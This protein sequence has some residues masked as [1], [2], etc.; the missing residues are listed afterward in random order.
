MQTTSL[1]LTLAF[2]INLTFTTRAYETRL[3]FKKRNEISDHNEFR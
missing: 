1:L 2:D 3:I